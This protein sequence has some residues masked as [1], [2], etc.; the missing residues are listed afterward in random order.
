MSKTKSLVVSGGLDI[1]CIV[2]SSKIF[3]KIVTCVNLWGRLHAYGVIRL[4]RS[5]KF[6][7][8]ASCGSQSLRWPSVILT[9]FIPCT[10][11]ILGL[12]CVT[13]STWQGDC[14]SLP[15]GGYE[16]HTS[17]LDTLWF[18]YSFTFFGPCMSEEA[19]SWV[20]QRKGRSS[21]NETPC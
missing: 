11:V 8:S 7:V 4:K 15:R 9:V 21:E 13:N 16:R 1:R 17:A 20:T 2:W 5:S 14:M 10:H 12:V 6:L 18:T 19:M 3:Y